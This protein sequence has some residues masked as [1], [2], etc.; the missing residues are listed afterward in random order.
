[1]VLLFLRSYELEEDLGSADPGP[2][3]NLLNR[4]LPNDTDQS[5]S[6]TFP[7]FQT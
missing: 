2:W 3:G 6:T 7:L 4:P 1:M 5:D